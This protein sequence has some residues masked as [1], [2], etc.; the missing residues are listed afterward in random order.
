MK[1]SL[2]ILLLLGGGW[3]WA[4]TNSPAPATHPTEVNSDSADFDL[5]L[6]RA[7]YHGHVSVVDP[8]IKLT[9]ELL[10]LDL[11][12][13]GGS[14]R[15]SHIL[16]ET[17]VIVDFA[18]DQGTKYHITS[19]KA[20]YNYKV[21]YVTNAVVTSVTNET[22]TFTG[23]PI[24]T[25]AQATIYADPMVWDRADGQLHFPKNPHIVSVQ[26]LNSGTNSPIPKF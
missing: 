25:T 24:A 16:A 8:K 20:V 26:N 22:V 21:N 17:N 1:K 6:R 18:D 13:N 15:L 7:S 10:V 5:K 2:L 11:P 4:Q 3:L 12:E 9:C 19:E 23:N 14:G